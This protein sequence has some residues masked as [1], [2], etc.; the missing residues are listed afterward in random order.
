[1]YSRIC[2][3]ASDTISNAVFISKFFLRSDSEKLWMMKGQLE[4]ELRRDD[5]A[6]STFAQAVKKCYN[7]IPL[8]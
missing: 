8:W 5:E 7:C 3:V 6:R 2:A 1:M 4:M